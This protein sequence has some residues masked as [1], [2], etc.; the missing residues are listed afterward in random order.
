MFSNRRGFC[1]NSGGMHKKGHQDEDGRII[2]AGSYTSDF[3]YEQFL[4]EWR[5]CLQENI[6][7][8]QEELRDAMSS[9]E[10]SEEEAILELHS[11]NM[12]SFYRET[13][14]INRFHSHDACVSC[15]TQISQHALPC[16]HILCTPC[17]KGY[18]SCEDRFSFSLTRCPL[19]CHR[20]RWPRPFIIRFKPDF[21]G[22]R[23]LSLDGYV[24]LNFLTR[25]K[26]ILP[27]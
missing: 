15:F 27:Q 22:L 3:T 9:H 25:S 16:G 13:K 19:Q 4:D 6:S 5:L 7:Q 1:V 2:A 23:V 20:Q 18:G 21:A 17:V 10:V 12:R 8:L 14:Q 26:S 24:C 11:E